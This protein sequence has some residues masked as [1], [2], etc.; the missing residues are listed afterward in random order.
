MLFAKTFH[1]NG[2]LIK[3]VM[4]LAYPVRTNILTYDAI[5]AKSSTTDV[6]NLLYFSRRIEKYV[7]I[8]K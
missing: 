2:S 4:I 3:E 6:Y 8:L 7:C 1:K 5:Y